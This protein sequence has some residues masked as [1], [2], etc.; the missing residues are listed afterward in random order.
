VDSGDPDPDFRTAYG[1]SG[2]GSTDGDLRS[3]NRAAMVEN[4][5]PPVRNVVALYGTHPL[6][7]RSTWAVPRLNA[8]LLTSLAAARA[9][10]RV[11]AFS[12]EARELPGVETVGVELP[13][14]AR[15]RL[16]LWQHR[17]GRW[18]SVPK[19]GQRYRYNL[20]KWLWANAGA[21]RLAAR[22]P[23]GRSTIIICTHAEAVLAARRCMP[24]SWIVHW[25]HNPLT[26]RFVDAGLAADASVVPSVAVYRDSWRRLGYQYPS[27]L[28]VIPNW[29]DTDA[30][31]PPTPERRRSS[32]RAFGIDDDDLVITFVG[33]HWIK[34]GQVVE[35]SLAAL[36]PSHRRIVLLT[37][38]EASRRREA[39]GA[40][41]EVRSLGRLPPEEL[42]QVYEAADV[43]V[44]PSVH[45]ENMPLA[46]LEMM[47]CGLPVV[48]SR[49]GGLPEIVTDRTTGRL[50]D[51]PNLVESWSEVV[52]ELLDAPDLR[53]ALGSAARA[54]VVERFSPEHA[55]GAWLRVL[56]QFGPPGAADPVH[57]DAG[58][59][60]S[61]ELT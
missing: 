2:A 3:V 50:I 10:W 46:A 32:R 28:W 22:V 1:V 44:V 18:L 61:A 59:D 45:E 42:V 5:H 57:A 34:G 24:R 38:G 49:A 17:A 8:E 51:L 15:A 39:L 60:P 7:L 41:V 4:G 9:D 26:Q 37:A 30:Y 40:G 33:R 35:R 52:S 53:E 31:R 56:A 6:D 13:P 43:G 21:S 16:R 36:A 20:Q 55:C 19:P 12:P 47:A 14:M 27:P 25:L 58:H 54:A 29:I 23:D 11:H 48:A